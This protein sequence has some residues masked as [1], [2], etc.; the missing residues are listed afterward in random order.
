MLQR[1]VTTPAFTTSTCCLNS[2]MQCLNIHK[3]K[4]LA[5]AAPL[6]A[7]L[8]WWSLIQALPASAAEFSVSPIKLQFESTMRSG[9][10]TV[11]NTDNRT[12]RFQLRL[13]EWTQDANGED[14]Y[15]PSN[16]LI[17]FP[18]Q[19]SSASGDK[20][21]VRVGPKSNLSGPEK[22]YRWRVEELPEENQVVTESVLNFTISFAIPVFIGATDAKPKAML[23]PLEMHDGLLSTTVKNTGK[24]QFRI[25]NV[26]VQG[27]DGFSQKVAGWY[28]LA[29]SKR[30]YSLS[31]P[32]EACR[33]SKHLNLVVK[34]GDQ[35]FTSG[36]DIAPAMCGT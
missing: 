11:R 24:S 17:F 20:A 6:G 26:E 34:V 9:T 31:I 22:T 21:I 10:I 8:V 16:D 23:M 4:A 19:L 33:A 12:I 27:A 29:G 14:V 13:V 32:N 2:P 35:D 25:E 28:L 30:E 15:T 7:V 5:K 18:H 36:L 3:M 1:L